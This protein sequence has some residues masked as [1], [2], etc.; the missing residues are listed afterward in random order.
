MRSDDKIRFENWLLKWNH[1]LGSHWSIYTFVKAAWKAAIKFERERVL[2]IL[3]D[4]QCEEARDE[5]RKLY[6]PKEYED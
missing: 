1:Q 3:D 5:I 6:N 2:K 4:I